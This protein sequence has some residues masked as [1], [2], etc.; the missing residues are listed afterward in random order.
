MRISVSVPV[1]R[2]TRL[3]ASIQTERPGPV[4]VWATHG[5]S[6]LRLAA[7]TVLH[8]PAPRGQYR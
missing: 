7:S 3:G 2:T 8:F 4:T 5:L 6:G 1:A